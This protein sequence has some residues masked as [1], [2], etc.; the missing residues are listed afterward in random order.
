[1]V[2]SLTDSLQWTQR[3]VALSVLVQT[4]ELL[5]VRGIFADDGVWRWEILKAEHEA[6]PGPLR[7]LFA[8]L[9]PYR[10]FS[11]LLW[12]RIGLATALACGLD[13]AA[14]PLFVSQLAIAVRFRGTFNGGSDYMT[15]VVLSALGLASLAPANETMARACLGYVCV[16]LVL[17]YSIAGVAKLRQPAWWKGAA[18]RSFVTSPRYAAPRWISTLVARAALPLSW[19]VLAFE[20]AFPV[21]LTGPRVALGF[22]CA[23]AVFHS[24]NALAFGLNRFLWAWAAAYPA[25]F[26]FSSAL[27][28]G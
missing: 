23:G 19:P 27:A 28:R 1:M 14:L 21:A 9:L 11:L 24:M 15:M 5:H 26:Y 16:Q 13:G 25:L 2:F 12:S 17:S 22:A 4:L 6:L 7:W 8:R 3:L 20:V 18:L 10:P